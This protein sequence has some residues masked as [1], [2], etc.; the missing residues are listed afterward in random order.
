MVP[1]T[2]SV[3]RIFLS[4]KKVSTQHFEFVCLLRFLRY[5]H[6]VCEGLRYWVIFMRYLSFVC[7]GFWVI[8][9]RFVRYL[10]FVWGFW[11]TFFCLLICFRYLSYLFLR[12]LSYLSFVWGFLGIWFVWSD[13]ELFELSFCWIFKTCNIVVAIQI[14]HT[15]ANSL[16]GHSW[17]KNL[18]FDTFALRSD[19]TVMSKWAVIS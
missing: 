15:V 4:V 8:F 7:W 1:S 13:F 18:N 10:R 17:K 19:T 6:F 12:F 16:C 3:F 9:M 11:D 5:L 14:I 2:I